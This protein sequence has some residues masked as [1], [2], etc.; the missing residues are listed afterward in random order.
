MEFSTR[1]DKEISEQS[2]WRKGLTSSIKIKSEM[3]DAIEKEDIENALE[4][5]SSL[6]DDDIKVKVSG[7]KVTLKG[8][9]H[10]FYQKDEAERI[11][12]NAQV[13]L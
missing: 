6:D 9:V 13:F 7:N 3:H 4:R 1:S 12:W 8:T 11:A 10:S 5:N 2:D